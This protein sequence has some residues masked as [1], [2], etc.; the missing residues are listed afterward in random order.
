MAG[1]SSIQ[2]EV[3]ALLIPRAHDAVFIPGAQQVKRQSNNMQG[4]N[5]NGS[6]IGIYVQCAF[7][8]SSGEIKKQ[9]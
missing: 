8:C 9:K 7:V 1:G 3:T 2:T 4:T 6:T 5:P